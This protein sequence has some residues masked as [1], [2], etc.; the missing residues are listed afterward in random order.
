MS[1]RPKIKFTRLAAGHA[2]DDY[3]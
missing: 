3:W 1:D 2:K